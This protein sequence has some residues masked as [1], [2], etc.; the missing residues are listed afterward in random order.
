MGHLDAGL[1]GARGEAAH[2]RQ[3][4]AGRLGQGGEHGEVTHDAALALDE[5]Q[6]GGPGLAH[7]FTLG[8]GP[9]GRAPVTGQYCANRVY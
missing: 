5:H 6:R 2:G 9:S 3:G 4:R 1:A 8:N 7:A